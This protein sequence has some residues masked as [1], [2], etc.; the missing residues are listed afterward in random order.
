VTSGASMSW[1]DLVVYL[2][3]HHV[4]PT[5]AQTVARF[6]ALQWHRDGLAPFMI[7][8]GRTDHGDATI[9]AAQ[10]W[11]AKSFSIADPVEEMVRRSGLAERT[12]TRRFAQATGHAPLA[13]VQQLR[14][15]D[16]KR[17]LERTQDSVEEVGWRVG[18]EDQAFFR[19]LFKRATGITPGQY[20][21]QFRIPAQVEKALRR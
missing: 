15:E 8:D 13:Y 2:I 11:L 12:F 7:F 20:R 17:R 1:H 5:A 18:Y 21:K 9:L 4:S 6:F 10:Q 14:V 19:R 16:A 3:A